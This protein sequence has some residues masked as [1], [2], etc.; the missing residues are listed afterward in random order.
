MVGSG[1]TWLVLACLLLAARAGTIASKVASLNCG[2]LAAP[3]HILLPPV[4]YGAADVDDLP[5]ADETISATHGKETDPGIATRY[6][7]APHFKCCAQKVCAELVVSNV[8]A[9][10]SL[11]MCLQPGTGRARFQ[12]KLRE[13]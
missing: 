5:L 4:G 9:T 6:A 2:K 7:A 8:A 12:R 11:C 1:R 13:V 10:I 3:E